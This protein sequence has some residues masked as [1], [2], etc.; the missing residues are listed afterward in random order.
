MVI[1]IFHADDWRLPPPPPARS[2]TTRASCNKRSPKTAPNSLARSWLAARA[3]SSAATHQLQGP[4]YA[5]AVHLADAVQNVSIGKVFWTK[6]F[7]SWRQYELSAHPACSS[8]WQSC[9]KLV[10]RH[11]GGYRL[12]RWLA[13]GLARESPAP[14]R[15]CASP[16]QASPMP[17]IEK[18]SS[19]GQRWIS[20][21][22]SH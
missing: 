18:A 4:S 1:G 12:C 14:S 13:K 19:S 9:Q 7:H 16:G 3:K 8:R 17:H 21:R 5:A 15:V 20:V 6:A 22:V 2:S 10:R 11:T